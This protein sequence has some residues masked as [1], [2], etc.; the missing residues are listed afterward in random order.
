MTWK[1]RGHTSALTPSRPQGASKASDLTCHS[2][3]GPLCHAWSSGLSRLLPASLSQIPSSEVM[4]SP[5]TQSLWDHP[6]R[7]LFMRPVLPRPAPLTHCVLESARA[8]SQG[9][10]CACPTSPVSSV[11]QHRPCPHRPVCSRSKPRPLPFASK[12]RF[13]RLI[14][15]DYFLH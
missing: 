4:K 12:T 6:C 1:A 15:A 7:G 10:C 11:G 5:F 13:G 14:A 9:C 3:Q 8:A 2:F